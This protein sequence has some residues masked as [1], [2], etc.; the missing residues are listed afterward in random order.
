MCV[1]QFLHCLD[2]VVE[3]VGLLAQQRVLAPQVGSHVGV[4][5]VEQGA[6]VVEWEPDCPVHQHKVQAL[7]VGVGV[8]AIAGRSADARHHETDVVVVMQ[9][10][11]GDTREG[12]YRTDG[13]GVHTATIDPDVT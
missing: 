6:D 10:A 13:P 7:D 9:S 11:D 5:V 4:T 3:A 2:R 1:H 8:A 12:G